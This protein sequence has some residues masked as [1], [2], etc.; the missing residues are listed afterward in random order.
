LKKK[1]IFKINIK[2]VSKLEHLEINQI[3]ISRDF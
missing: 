3:I 2:L 1:I